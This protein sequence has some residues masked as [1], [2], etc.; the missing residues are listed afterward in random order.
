[1][2]SGLAGTGQIR[3]AGARIPHLDQGAVGRILEKAQSSDYAT[4]QSNVN[5][6]LDLEL[7]KQALR[8]IDATAPASL[9]A[10]VVRVGPFEAKVPGDNAVMQA[11]FDLRSFTMEIHAAFTESTTPK[12]WSGASPAVNIVVK[13]PIEA[14]AREVD[15]GLFV[16]GLAAQAIARETDRIA[17]LESDIRERAFFNRRLKAG[18]FMRRRELELDAYATEK[19]RLKSEVDRRRVEA[20][21]LKVDEER[22]KTALPEQ[23]TTA[24]PLSNE[25]PQFSTNPSATNPQPPVPMPRPLSPT[26][27]TDPTASGLY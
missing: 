21:T 7:N 8:I 1:L 19:A 17:A 2:V 23:Q 10:G 13:G 11:N 14:S 15:S 27:Q 6:A 20:E 18:Q 3:L 16:A 26:R 5:R 12:Y 9:T 24:A 4:D 25:A 22:R